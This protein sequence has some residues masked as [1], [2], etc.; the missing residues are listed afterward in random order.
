MFRFLRAGFVGSFVV[1]VSRVLGERD[2]RMSDVG[3]VVGIEVADG[4]FVAAV[5][6]ARMSFGFGLVRI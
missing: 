6:V 3:A 4:F 2:T 5:F 1:V